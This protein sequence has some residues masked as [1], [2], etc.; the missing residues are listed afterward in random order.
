[1]Q[2]IFIKK[3]LE[4]Y[5][6]N[7]KTIISFVLGFTLIA[8]IYSFIAPAEYLS[9]ASLFPPKKTEATGGLS[10]MLKNFTGGGMLSL[11]GISESNQG[12]VFAEIIMS[13][14]VAEHVIDKCKLKDKRQYSNLRHEKLVKQVKK[15]IDVV[16][17]KSG[18][19][20]LYT[21]AKS[22][23]FVFGEERKKTAKLSQDMAN[24][25]IYALDSILR[26]RTILAAKTSLKYSEN[27]AE[28][29]RK[30]LDS[31]E[32][33][34][35]NFQTK[36]KILEIE[37]QTKSLLNQQ[38]AIAAELMI[39][40]A[41]LKAAR[42]EFSDNSLVVQQLQTKVESLRRNYDRAQKG[43]I[44][45]NDEYSIPFAEIPELAKEYA[46][47]YRD[48]KIYEQVLVYLETQRHQDA[49]Q[50]AKDISQVEILDAPSLPEKPVAPDK[51]LMSI[52]AFVLS[53]S[54]ILVYLALKAKI[55]G[56]LKIPVDN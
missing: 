10:S 43:G 6:K 33:K 32:L 46:T 31:I 22:P 34:L 44:F 9:E 54:I 41:E 25:V 16:I 23:F 49:L 39:A 8:L 40:E 52:L 12:Q 55:K 11:G 1:M 36:N 2:N 4:V 19:I 26:N 47:L 21:V 56:E 35:Q 29:Y 20:Y 13:R 3:L 45:A 24:T 17:D 38:A 27:E 28:Q 14:S 37:E 30:K 51:I 7:I 42:K 18:M 48:K 50:Q 53:T 5:K 15:S